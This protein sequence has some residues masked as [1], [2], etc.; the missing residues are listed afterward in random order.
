VIDGSVTGT[1]SSDLE[2][3]QY[4]FEQGFRFSMVQDALAFSA[5][6]GTGGSKGEGE[7]KRVLWD[8]EGGAN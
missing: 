2:Q 1:G 3:L 6:P 4:S 8:E 5:A 7:G